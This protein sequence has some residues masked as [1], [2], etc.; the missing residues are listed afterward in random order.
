MSYLNILI[1]HVGDLAT[2][3]SI[4]NPFL[5][6]ISRRYYPKEDQ[7][8]R[9]RSGQRIGRSHEVTIWLANET[10]YLYCD[11]VARNGPIRSPAPSNRRK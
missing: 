4:L 5:G 8:G 10:D 1:L 2:L 6:K 7:E 3:G 9:K 11:F